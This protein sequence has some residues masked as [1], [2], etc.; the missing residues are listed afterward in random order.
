MQIHSILKI[1]RKTNK[2]IKDLLDKI[3]LKEMLHLEEEEDI[4]DD[5]IFFNS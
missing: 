3:V 2:I 1:Y 5:F 4:E